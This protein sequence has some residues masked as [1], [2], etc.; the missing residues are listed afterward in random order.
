[1]KSIKFNVTT[2]IILTTIIVLV[3]GFSIAFMMISDH[4]FEPETFVTEQVVTRDDN[5][6]FKRIIVRYPTRGNV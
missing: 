4:V 6:F 2:A 5:M 1:M 3:G